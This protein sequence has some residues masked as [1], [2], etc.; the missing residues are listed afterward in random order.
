MIHIPGK[1][2]ITI[3]PFF[4]LTAGLIGFLNSRSLV[5]T[6]VWIF[7]IFISVLVHEF[8]HG[9]TARAFGL[10]P[11]IELVAL[12]GLTYHQ[13]DKLPF[14]KQFFIVLNGPEFVFSP[15]EIATSTSKTL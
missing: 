13:G 12:G 6:L 5:G 3:R 11:R 1:I 15:M 7:V 9:L 8:G 2:P 4:F 10:K 14:L